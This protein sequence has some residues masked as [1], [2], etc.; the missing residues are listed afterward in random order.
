MLVLVGNTWNHKTVRWLPTLCMYLTNSSTT[1][2]MWPEV[3]FLAEYSWFE[4]SAFLLPYWL[5]LQDNSIKSFPLFTP[6]W[7]R[8]D[9]SMLFPKAWT[10]SETH[11]AFSMIWT[12]FT[13]SLS[14]NDKSYAKPASFYFSVSSTEKDI[15]T[16]LTKAWTA[17][18]K[19]SIIWKSNLTDKM[20]RSFFEA[21]V[22]LI[23]Q[24]GCAN[25]T[26]G[27]EARRQ[28]H[29]NVARNIE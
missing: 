25:K 18:D 29:K 24:Y 3:N 1:N 21:A 16:R 13:E 10:R 6:I 23:L 5:L 7:A 20:K 22:V 27:K 12:R 11:T 8:A 4:F 15:D 28:L 19:L 9:E 14:Y 2:R 17:I 26:A